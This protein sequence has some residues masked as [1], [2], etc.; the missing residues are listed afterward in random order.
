MAFIK[1]KKSDSF[2]H[3][4]KNKKKTVKSTGKQRNKKYFKIIYCSKG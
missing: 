2:L 3:A 1:K 4:K